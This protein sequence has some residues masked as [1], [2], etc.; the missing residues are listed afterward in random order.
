MVTLVFVYKEALLEVGSNG[1]CP[2]LV[3]VNGE[4][5]LLHL[6]HILKLTLHP[7]DIRNNFNM[8]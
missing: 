2:I 1:V 4:L 7:S 5:K 3:L 6:L 8:L